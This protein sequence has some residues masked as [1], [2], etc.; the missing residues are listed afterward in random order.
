MD[1]TKK[2]HFLS[3]QS[4]HHKMVNRLRAFVLDMK[5]AVDELIKNHLYAC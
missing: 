3:P 1:N 4:I 2:L 5:K